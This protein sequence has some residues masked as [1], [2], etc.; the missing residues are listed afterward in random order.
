[1]FSFDAFL[2]LTFIWAGII[3]LAIFIY[4]CLDGFDLGI[5]ILFPFAPSDE[6]RG[7]MLNSI[8]PF[9]DG[10]ETWLILGGGGLFAAFPLAYSILLPAFYIPVLTM[11]IALVFRGVAFEFHYKAS[12]KRR[13]I[14]DYAFHF[15]S[16]VAAFAQGVMLGAFVQGVSVEGRH[17]SGGPF[18]WATPFA[19]MTGVA[20]ICGYALLGST[21]V[22]MKTEAGTQVWA[23]RVSRYVLLYM[24]LFMSAVSLWLP[25][26]K[27]EIYRR[28]FTWPSI[29][30]LS[31]IPITATILMIMLIQSLRHNKEIQPFL[32]TIGLFT[33]NY[34]GLL[35]CIYPWIVPHSVQ[36]SDAAAVGPSLSL[37][38]VGVAITLPM[39][40][41]YTAYNY[42]IF[43][44][45]SSHEDLY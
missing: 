2:N 43:R 12:P 26:L 9:W 4:V 3:G 29:L 21:W 15:G 22:I 20:L 42:Y 1:M 35:I 31:P 32:F 16:L 41:I 33:L 19:M 5:G 45:K 44:G 14:W 11:L 17:F 6:C 27:D 25:F 39:I 13:F 37:M 36:F 28:W 40:L 23:R 34:I 38:L 30:H 7:R 8:A 24:I 18:D 10:N